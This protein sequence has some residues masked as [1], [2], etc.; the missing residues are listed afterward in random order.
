M[1][2]FHGYLP[3][4]TTDGFHAAVREFEAAAAESRMPSDQAIA[5][6]AAE[7]AEPHGQLWTMLYDDEADPNQ[8]DTLDE[9]DAWLNQ[10]DGEDFEHEFRIL[11]TGLREWVETW[12]N[13]DYGW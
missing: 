4:P 9:I 7:F 13:M 1:T 5:D 2:Y 11:L 10:I 3:R 6:A 12:D 8:G